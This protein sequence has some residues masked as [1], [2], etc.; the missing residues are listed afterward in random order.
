[1]LYRSALAADEDIRKWEIFTHD[2]FDTASIGS[3]ALLAALFRNLKAEIAFWLGK[4]VITVFNDF[5]KFFDTIDILTLLAEA[6]QTGFPC[7]SLP[8]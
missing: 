4:H 5:N 1:M 6:I 7:Q 3:S 2:N 8:F